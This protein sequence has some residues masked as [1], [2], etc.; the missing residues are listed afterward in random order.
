MILS[1]SSVNVFATGKNLLKLTNVK[2]GTIMNSVTVEKTETENQ[3]EME[4]WMISF[5]NF[6][7]TFDTELQFESWM[8]KDFSVNFQTSVAVDQEMCF[9]AWM[10]EPFLASTPD[11]FNEKEMEFESWMLT[12]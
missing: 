5:N 3:L 1:L 11:S 12:F 4:N 9:E 7:K 10:M 8:M 6:S 2:A